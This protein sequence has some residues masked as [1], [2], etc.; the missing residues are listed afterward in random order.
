ME[1]TWAET[2]YGTIQNEETVPWFGKFIIDGK[3]DGI[4]D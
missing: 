4:I 2:N 3:S 1:Q